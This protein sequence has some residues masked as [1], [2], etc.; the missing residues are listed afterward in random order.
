MSDVPPRVR[1]VRVVTGRT[2]ELTFRDGT[3]RRLDLA[4]MLWG[5]M[6]ADIAG[7]DA[8]FAEVRVDQE[9]GTLVWP[10]GA[11]I[12]PDVLYGAVDPA[13]RPGASRAA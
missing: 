13:P 5:P 6:F 1:S 12:D 10:N 8:V 7:D 9:L 4:P 11:D 3:Q 2:V